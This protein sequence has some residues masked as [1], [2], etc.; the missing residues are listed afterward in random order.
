MLDIDRQVSYWRNGANEDWS[1]A[2]FLVEGGRTRHGLFLLHLA[3]EK[4]LKA[5]VCRAT[6]DV[7]PRLHNLVRLA[8]IAGITLTSEQLDVLG[9]LN[10]FNMEGRYPEISAEPLTPEEASAYVRRAQE[11]FACL[12]RES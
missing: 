12:M 6:R 5:L 10:V 7:P 9:E 8:E 2:I 1:A 3:I 11:V 4:A